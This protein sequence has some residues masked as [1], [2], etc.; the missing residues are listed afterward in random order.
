MPAGIC[1]I[2]SRRYRPSAASPYFFETAFE[3][4]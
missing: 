4:P 2:A 3:G 1:F